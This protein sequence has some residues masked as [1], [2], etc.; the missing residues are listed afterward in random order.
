MRER[1]RFEHELKALQF[2]LE[3]YS[4]REWA[5]P[6]SRES[7]A[8]PTVKDGRDADE[9]IV[10]L[11]DGT[12]YYVRRKVRAQFLTRPGRPRVGFCR[13]DKRVF[14][15]LAWCEGTQGTIDAGA[16]APAALKELLN[17]LTSQIKNRA[18]R[19]DIKQ[20]LENAQ[21]QPFLKLDITKVKDWKITGDIKLDINRTGIIST[22]A[23]VSFDKGWIKVGA[24]YKDDGT[25]KQV[26]LKV[27]LPL[28]GRKVSGKKC[29]EQQI[30][31]WWDVECLREVPTIDTISVPGF[32]ENK[33]T[34]YLYFE[35]AKAFLRREPKATAEPSDVIDRI[36]KSKPTLGTALLN[37]RSLQRLDYLVGQGYWLDSVKGFTSPEGR[38][39]KAGSKDR[40]AAATWE[41]NDELAEK[42]AKKVRDLI[43][44]RYVKITTLKMR[45]LP[46][47]M[48][49]PTGKSMPAGVGRSECPKLEERPG[50]EL[51]KA[52]LDRAMIHGGV[53][54][55]CCER[56]PSLAQGD[57]QGPFVKQCP[58]ELARMTEGDRKFIVNKG[59]S[60]RNR[61]ERL[62][63]N[64]R[65]VEIH[66]L[67]REKLRDVDMPGTRLEHEHN[68]PSEVLQAAERKWGPQIPFIKPDPPLCI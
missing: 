56:A 25:G 31:L 17:T 2:A 11:A 24:E 36:L 43:E 18:S 47:R 62:F 4:E 15:R 14:F 55:E 48:R 57:K 50:V 8:P 40:G 7:G 9:I 52:K 10:T 13:D 64:L 67:K 29:P 12:R 19:S 28:G 44:D 60:D 42:R 41:G 37:R 54:F 27:D 16:D 1:H 39:G 35:Y 3:P 34:L 32:R 49:F 5:D 65:R 20:T 22:Q 53:V 66:L 46:P 26:Q 38:R 33:E 21:L 23:G 30:V 58:T 45:D 59:F 61:A 63:Q 68:C 51:E 6:W